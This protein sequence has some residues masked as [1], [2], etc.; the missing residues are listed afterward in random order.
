MAAVRSIID[1]V[2][3]RNDKPHSWPDQT[4]VQ[5]IFDYV[6]IV[7]GREIVSPA[8]LS[9]SEAQATKVVWREYNKSWFRLVLYYSLAYNYGREIPV[10]DFCSGDI[11]EFRNP[12][13][14][15]RGG[16]AGIGLVRSDAWLFAKG[17]DVVLPIP[18]QSSEI[19]SAMRLG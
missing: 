11:V 16:T 5:F 19:I 2:A 7:L 18:I 13:I 14:E 17:E 1:T 6:K 9:L 12:Y 10:G 3:S 4:C 15:Y 8:I